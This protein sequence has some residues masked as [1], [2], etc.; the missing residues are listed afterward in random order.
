MTLRESLPGLAVSSP[1]TGGAALLFTHK[2]AG[3]SFDCRRLD[4]T[5]DRFKVLRPVEA[6][7]SLIILRAQVYDRGINGNDAAAPLEEAVQR[8]GVEFQLPLIVI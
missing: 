6:Y 3:K 2:I 4:Q 1:R 7:L 5:A 8:V